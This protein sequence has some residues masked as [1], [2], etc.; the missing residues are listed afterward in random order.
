M[1][2]ILSAKDEEAI[3]N[4]VGAQSRLSTHDKCSTR[5]GRAH[6]QDIREGRPRI[7]KCQDDYSPKARVNTQK[8][9]PYTLSQGRLRLPVS[10]IIIAITVLLR[11]NSQALHIH[12]LDLHLLSSRFLF[13]ACLLQRA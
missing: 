1:D 13:P 2:N 10:S 7:K 9:P 12:M 4:K 6:Q 11:N 5:S 8:N 3:R